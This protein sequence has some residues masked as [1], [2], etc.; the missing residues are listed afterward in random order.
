MIIDFV[1]F[2]IAAYGFLVGFKA[3]VVN[4]LLTGFSIFS[5]FVLAV[6]FTSSM[7]V[8]LKDMFLLDSAILPF[9]A[10]ILAFVFSM[11]I[12]RFM[13]EFLEV[14]LK[15]MGLDMFDQVAGGLLVSLVSLFLYSGMLWFLQKAEVIS[16][17]I[18]VID[19][20]WAKKNALNYRLINPDEIL[21]VKDTPDS[22]HVFETLP[23][24]DEAI[25]RVLAK[26][27]REK[28]SYHNSIS[29][30]V[31]NIFLYQ[32]DKFMH[33]LRDMTNILWK[34]IK[35]LTKDDDEINPDVENA[36]E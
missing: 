28:S 21:I 6:R 35:E 16:A 3:G 18:E 4:I 2:A 24:A 19:E 9:I 8:F 13:A 30:A 7:Y 32:F 14:F 31:V 12:I 17:K 10:F 5:G 25:H 33:S 1:F 36:I 29:I 23:F 34:D 22:L 11:L 26:T 20:V 15:S 27:P